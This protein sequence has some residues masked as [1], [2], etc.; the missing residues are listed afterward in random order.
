MIAISSNP[1]ESK[2]VTHIIRSKVIQSP[3]NLNLLLGIKK[4]IGK[5]LPFSKGALN[6]LKAGDVAEEVADGLVWISGVRMWVLS[7]VNTSVAGMIYAEHSA[8]CDSRL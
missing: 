3:C 7:G 6:N 5:L 8:R 1:P 4:S 2:P